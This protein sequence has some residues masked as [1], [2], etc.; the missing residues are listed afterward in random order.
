ME[1]KKKRNSMGQKMKQTP[2]ER[3]RKWPMKKCCAKNVMRY[4][5]L[6]RQ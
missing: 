2:E 4:R 5:G 6:T 1:G 3:R